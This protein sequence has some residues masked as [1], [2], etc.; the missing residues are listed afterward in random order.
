MSESF[1]EE[2]AILLA[3]DR[4]RGSKEGGKSRG[5]RK[6]RRY[7][8]G[9][10]EVMV[11][12]TGWGHSPHGL[13]KNGKTTRSIIGHALYI[14]RHGKLEAE[15]SD[16]STID[17]KEAM[18]E[19]L[20]RKYAPKDGHAKA[21]NRESLHM[22]L[23]MPA[24][25]D[26]E[27]VRQAARAFL[28]K[29]YGDNRPYIFVLHTDTENPHVHALIKNE[30]YDGRK[31]DYQKGELQKLREEFAFE[32][33]ERGVFADATPRATRGVV[34]KAIKQTIRHIVQGDPDRKTPRSP[35]RSHVLEAQV[36]DAIVN[37]E[38][39]G[40]WLE[41]IKARQADIRSALLAEA[42]ALRD[43]QDGR[44]DKMASLI[45]GFVARMPAPMTRRDRIRADAH[46]KM[47][48]RGGELDAREAARRGDESE[49]QNVI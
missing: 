29:R 2:L 38:D 18:E 6:P 12:I 15:T 5:G 32:M 44:A 46:A 10:P 16:G 14:T 48:Q 40:P 31:L 19:Y 36:K 41:K 33:N 7:L 37:G 20:G 23:S 27:D 3:Q 47:A 39:T 13:M 42:Q 30:G 43:K 8:A 34:E 26:P 4:G 22:V 45:E 25:T 35:R 49:E 21:N 11:K 9:A 17:G 28:Q 24:G 1:D